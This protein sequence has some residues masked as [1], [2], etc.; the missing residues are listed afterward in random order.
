MLK[1]RQ[2]TLLLG[3]ED[4]VQILSLKN[5]NNIEDYSSDLAVEGWKVLAYEWLFRSLDGPRGI[6][7]SAK[8][9]KHKYYIF[10]LI[11]EI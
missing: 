3:K 9:D 11:C 2:D 8:S 5:W 10:S 1:R 6:T 7:L 4:L